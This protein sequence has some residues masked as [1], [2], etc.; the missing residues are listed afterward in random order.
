MGASR[1]PAGWPPS[2]RRSRANAISGT[3][4]IGVPRRR[5]GWSGWWP[6]RRRN[7]RRPN[8]TRLRWPPAERPATGPPPCRWAIE[9]G[10]E[11]G[12]P[13]SLRGAQLDPLASPHHP[14]LAGA[15]LSR[16]DSPRRCGRTGAKRGDADLLPL[17]VPEVRRML[18]AVPRA[19]ARPPGLPDGRPAPP[20][21]GRAARADR[22]TVGAGRAAAAPGGRD[23]T[24]AP[25]RPNR[26]HRDPVDDPDR[27][28]VERG[29]R[30]VRDGRHAAPP[31]PPPAERR[32]VGRHPRGA[33]GSRSA[34]R[35]LT[36]TV[37]LAPRPPSPRRSRGR[38]NTPPTVGFPLP[39]LGEGWR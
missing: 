25:R 24:T 5:R 17:T 7:G 19:P 33:P 34:H 21:A 2:P 14:G 29:P 1:P 30:G 35:P 4:C 18:L 8:G 26:A 9:V 23:R 28:C 16:G 32:D 36:V 37:V 12:R 20:D 11:D 3:C 38:G 27:R 10:F 13:R 22:R 39:C 31:L 15:R 6:Q